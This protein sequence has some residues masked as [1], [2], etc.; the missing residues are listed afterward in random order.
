MVGKLGD[1]DIGRSTLKNFKDLGVNT[2]YISTAVGTASGVA[3]IN[4]IQGGQNSIVIAPG[5]NILLN[6][7]DLEVAKEVITGCKVLLCQ[8]EIHPDITLAAMLMAKGK[9]PLVLTISC[10]V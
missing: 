3:A 5:A 10:F 1:D 7:S 8:N 9:G 2:E 6:Q 4:V